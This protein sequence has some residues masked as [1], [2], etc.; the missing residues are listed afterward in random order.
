[1]ESKTSE[2]FKLWSWSF[3]SKCVKVCVDSKNA[4]K[5]AEKD[6]NFWDNGVLTCCGNFP[7]L[8]WEY[9]WLAV[10]VLPNSPKIS[11]LTNMM[12]SDSECL[13][14]MEN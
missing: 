2:T 11:D 8:S 7:Q 14:L 3:L 10:N 1:M 13:G 4:I 12:F 5:I 9:M 6:F